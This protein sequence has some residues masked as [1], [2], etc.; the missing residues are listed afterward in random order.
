MV[1]SIG[2]VWSFAALARH[3]LVR[4]LARRPRWKPQPRTVRKQRL[5]FEPLSFE[6]RVLT[7]EALGTLGAPI[8]FGGL[9]GKLPK[10]EPI[11]SV[12]LGAADAREFS[13]WAVAADPLSVWALVAPDES[14]RP[15]TPP[16]QFA[17]ESPPRKSK[18][19]DEE[20]NEGYSPPGWWSVAVDLDLHVEGGDEENSPYLPNW[21]GPHL[22]APWTEADNSGIGI[23]PQGEGPKAG[24][25][26]SPSAMEPR[27]TPNGT[28]APNDDSAAATLD[29]APP[30][31]DESVRKS[32]PWQDSGTPVDPFEAHETFS[33][34]SI[35]VPP[36]GPGLV[37]SEFLADPAGAD[38]PFEYVELRATRDIDFSATPFSIVFA[39][40]N[41][42]TSGWASGGIST[43]GFEISTGFA[44][45]G[46][47]VY[48]GGSPTFLVMR[49]GFFADSDAWARAPKS[50]GEQLAMNSWKKAFRV[51]IATNVSLPFDSS[52]RSPRVL[53]RTVESAG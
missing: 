49:L 33:L 16:P 13:G 6:P 25:E 38:S 3:L 19:D 45:Q 50:N 10:F 11:A 32:R 48:L 26:Q 23:P 28:V 5:S 39:E 29:A 51:E 14:A 27:P 24:T 4:C 12:D 40:T 9:V 36:L 46:S 42:G 43:Y 1:R 35:V 52:H 34:Q 44:Y 22:P 15:S 37:I 53:G 20:E 8:L 21:T 47:V 31:D 17:S 18:F 7:T 30:S 41:V 2:R